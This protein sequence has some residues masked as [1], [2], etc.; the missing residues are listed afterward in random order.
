MR[1]EADDCFS[2]LEQESQAFGTESEERK[3][4]PRHG[5]LLSQL[6]PISNNP[7]DLV[8]EPLTVSDVLAIEKILSAE[9]IGYA[10]LYLSP[11][12]PPN[13]Y[14]F[15][16]TAANVANFLGR[17]QFGCHKMV[18][19]DI[20]DRFIVD[21]IGGFIDHCPDRAFLGALLTHLIPIQQGE[22]EP[23]DFPTVTRDKYKLYGL[24]LDRLNAGASLDVVREQMN[25]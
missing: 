3:P 17:H 2:L 22:H 9:M 16:M 24:L 14:V 4:Y 5:A 12:E 15:N 23:E 7:D 21:T 1:T 25:A 18:L 10:Y 8:L 20:W 11:K 13:I 6:I 19:T